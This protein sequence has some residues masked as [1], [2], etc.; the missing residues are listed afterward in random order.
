MFALSVVLLS[1]PYAVLSQHR[2]YGDHGALM[3]SSPNHKP[4]HILPY[5]SP[6]YIGSFGTQRQRYAHPQ[7]PLRAAHHS[8]GPCTN[9]V[10]DNGE[11][12]IDDRSKHRVHQGAVEPH[13]SPRGSGNDGDHE[14]DRAYRVYYNRRTSGHHGRDDGASGNPDLV[15]HD[16]GHAEEEPYGPSEPH[17]ADYGPRPDGDHRY[18][19]P[20][21]IDYNDYYDA[22]HRAY[23]GNS[24]EHLYRMD[25]GGHHEGPR[26]SDGIYGDE[27]HDAGPSGV[28]NHCGGHEKDDSHRTSGYEGPYHGD[29][30][31]HR[32]YHQGHRP[33]HVVRHAR[34]QRQHRTQTHHGTHRKGQIGHDHLPVR[35]MKHEHHHPL[36]DYHLLAVQRHSGHLPG[37]GILHHGAM[38]HKHRNI[39]V[40]K[41]VKLTNDMHGEYSHSLPLPMVISEKPLI[42]SGDR[43]QHLIVDL[44]DA[45]PLTDHYEL[46]QPV[47]NAWFRGN[48][49]GPTI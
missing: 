39:V 43:S 5:K 36:V 26:H 21:E 48:G 1:H 17:E 7:I 12:S 4:R 14:N 45:T 25:G 40:G 42:L 37:H 28:F 31:K 8:D 10:S 9:Y 33:R 32:G 23:G 30:G 20:N 35:T 29:H 15:G 22:P 11:I 6:A 49:D 27:D 19:I 2:V 13:G 24:N 16:E 41:P 3:I 38:S 47:K 46:A 34:P 18:D 44:G